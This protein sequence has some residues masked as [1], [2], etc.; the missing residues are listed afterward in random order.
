MSCFSIRFPPA[1]KAWKSF[2]S[3]LQT[4]LHKLH[5][6]KAF[7]KP[8]NNGKNLQKAASKTTRPSLFLGQRLQL[9]SSRRRHALP[10]GYQ[11]YYL[12]VNK[13]A[14]PVY[15][16]KLFKDAP[17][18][19]V[20]E[21]IHQQPLKKNKKKLIDEAAEA[22]TSNEGEKQGDDKLES[23]GL[24][25]PMLYGIDARAEEF[26][27]SFRAEMERQE[28][29]A[30]D[31]CSH[32]SIS[33]FMS[34]FSIRFP[35][36]KKAWKSFTSKL[37]TRL[38]KLHKSKAFKKPKNNGKNLQ[39]AASKTTRP[40]LFLGQR[41]QLKSSRRRHALPFGYQRYYLSVN[42]AAAPVYIDKLFKDAPVSG[43]VEYIHQQPL[44]K[45]KKKLIDEA[46]EAGTSNEGEKQGDD[47]LESVGLLSPMLYGIDARA[48]EFIA[49]FRAE[50]ERQEIIARNL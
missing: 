10:F 43:V 13:A 46:A 34:C 32:L 5:K 36:A 49:S 42:K 12:S 15:I 21:Y 44:K 38:H 2:T 19:G 48:E 11:R 27:A 22:G 47:K 29:I 9:K 24:L 6:S 18:S 1:K 40:S 31:L 45:N 23:V 20:V 39:K 28:I 37:Q 8:K 16:D 7:K 3:K 14:A 35:P 25:S 33:L 30:P 41:L 50:M 4:R 26:I 17:V